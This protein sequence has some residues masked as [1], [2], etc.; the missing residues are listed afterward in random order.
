MREKT[1]S[2]RRRGPQRMGWLDGV[3][4]PMGM[5]VSKLQKMAKGREAWH[6]TVHGSQ[7]VKHD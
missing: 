6:A 4:D 7:R 3:T 2:R 5:S 1:E